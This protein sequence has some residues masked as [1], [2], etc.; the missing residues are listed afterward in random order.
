VRR[1]S[2]GSAATTNTREEFEMSDVYELADP[3]VGLWNEPD[4]LRRRQLI[5]ELWTED[6]VHILQPPQEIREIA[7]RPASA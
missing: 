6:G 7:A 4:A 2:S 1:G 3:Y 5:A